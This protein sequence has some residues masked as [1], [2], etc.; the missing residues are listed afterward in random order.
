MHLIK[1]ISLLLLILSFSSC[2]YIAN[3][4][5]ELLNKSSK[6]DSSSHEEAISDDNVFSINGITENHI[7]SSAIVGL[8][9]APD[10]M[11]NDWE[12]SW[13]YLQISDTVDLTNAKIKI[14]E[15]QFNFAS[16]KS[17]S[18]SD[19]I[20]GK[21][22]PKP[23]WNYSKLIAN[24]K[25]TPVTVRCILSI[26]GN[27]S[28]VAERNFLF[29]PINECLLDYVNP[30]GKPESSHFFLTAY[31]N[32]DDEEITKFINESSKNGIVK[33]ID[34]YQSNSREK[35]EKQVYALWHNLVVRK[36]RY[37]SILNT[38]LSN[39]KITSQYVRSVKE[40]CVD[41][42][43]NCADASVMFAS[44]LRKIGLDAYLIILPNH[45][46]VGYYSYSKNKSDPLWWTL[47]MTLLKGEEVS[48]NDRL[49]KKYSWDLFKQAQQLGANKMPSNKLLQ[50]S[51]QYDLY[52]L[53]D[54]TRAFIPPIPF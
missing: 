52:N 13:F 48:L 30:K 10:S 1:N 37:S 54:K 27:N 21:F 28:F 4:G 23:S 17:I 50:E 2:D 42:G 9:N 40:T 26:S 19:L 24:K 7:F 31:V 22:Y 16:Q 47:E 25:V 29:R 46:M 6:E 34:G 32:E 33:T 44:A 20:N 14:E 8:M 18:K 53:D 39:H 35:V 49:V 11:M 51:N 15:S 5:K 41:N 43:G 3:K 38:S 45:M 36:F 12:Y